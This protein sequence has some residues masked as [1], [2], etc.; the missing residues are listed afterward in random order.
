[1]VSG[2]TIVQS[3]ARSAFVLMPFPNTRRGRNGAPIQPERHHS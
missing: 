2:D 1:M 3:T